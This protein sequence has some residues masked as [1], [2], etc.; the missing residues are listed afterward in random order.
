M[1][2]NFRSVKTETNISLKNENFLPDSFYSNL[3]LLTQSKYWQ[4][5]VLIANLENHIPVASNYLH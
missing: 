3:G 2:F 5:F 4:L 1:L